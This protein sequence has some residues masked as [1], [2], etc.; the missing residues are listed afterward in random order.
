MR[1]QRTAHTTNGLVLV[2]TMACACSILT[3]C[4]GRETGTLG[5][6][7]VIK[8][9]YVLDESDDVVRV[10]GIVRNSGDLP[11]PEGELV[12]T[13]R[14]RTGSFRGENRVALP[15]LDAGAEEQFALAINSHGAVE[16]IEFEI[17]EPGT[18]TGGRPRAD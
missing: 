1:K 12:V 5:Q 6:L 13:L 8:H 2:F 18:I 10:V 11:A 4:P 7:S 9:R 15:E 14:S 3:G 16:S 17:V